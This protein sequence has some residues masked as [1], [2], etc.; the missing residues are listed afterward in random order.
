MFVNMNDKIAIGYDGIPG[1]L[2]KL[3][4]FPL[5]EIVCKLV[6]LSMNE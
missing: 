4:V 5:A 6:N 2:L 1:K 3:G